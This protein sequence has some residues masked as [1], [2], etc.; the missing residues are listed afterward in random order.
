MKNMISFLDGALARV[1]RVGVSSENQNACKA[2]RISTILT[3][4]LNI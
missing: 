2:L 4:Y 3:R 1:A